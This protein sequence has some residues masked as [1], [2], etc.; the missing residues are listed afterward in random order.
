MPIRFRRASE[1]LQEPE[2]VPPTQ[3]PRSYRFGSVALVWDE[4]REVFLTVMGRP[5]PLE[6]AA[7]LLDCVQRHMLH[8]ES[9]IERM[10]LEKPTEE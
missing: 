10:A 3:H 1:A 8:S 6:D 2:A 7:Y 5:M 9:A 4:D